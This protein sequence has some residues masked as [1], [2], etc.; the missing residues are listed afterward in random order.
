MGLGAVL[1]LHSATL[2]TPPLRD[3]P[4]ELSPETATFGDVELDESVELSIIATN[5]TATPVG[6]GEVALAPGGGAFIVANSCPDTLLAGARSMRCDRGLPAGDERRRCDNG[7]DDDE[8]GPSAPQ[9]T[10][11]R[12]RGRS[13]S[14]R[15]PD[16]RC[17]RPTDHRTHR[18]ATDRGR[19]HRRAHGRPTNRRPTNRRPSDRRPQH[20]RTARR[21][22]LRGAGPPMRRTSQE[23]EDRSRSDA[24]HDGRRDAAVRRDC[25]DPG[26]GTRRQHHHHQRAGRDGRD[27]RVAVPGAGAAARRGLPRRPTGLPAR[28]RSSTSRRSSGRGTWCP[29]RPAR[30][31]S[32]SRSARSP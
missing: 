9:W 1:A 20:R 15:R 2:L 24:F 21:R 8:W 31:R 28:G 17:R 16:D 12:W 23:F 10:G 18:R 25:H 11:C 29:S 14:N 32:M 5:V 4:L 3:Q 26:G 30:A 7:A 27:G 19:N 13:P 6:I 22:L